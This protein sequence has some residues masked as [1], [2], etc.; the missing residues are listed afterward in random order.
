MALYALEWCFS[1]ER[2]ARLAVRPQ[3]RAFLERL[4]SQG[5]LVAAGPWSD[6]SGALIILSAGR[7]EEVDHLLEADPY[8]T[9]AVGGER[10]VRE[11][12]PFIGGTIDATG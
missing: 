9:E 6:D 4:R 11:W 12:R 5:R 8:V 10:R 1:A 2:E 7:V 3:H